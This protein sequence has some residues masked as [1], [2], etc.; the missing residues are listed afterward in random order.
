[1][2]INRHKLDFVK[3]FNKNPGTTNVINGV[4]YDD[5]YFVNHYDSNTEAKLI[6]QNNFYIGEVLTSSSTGDGSEKLTI[7]EAIKKSIGPNTTDL[8]ALK[9]AVT[10]GAIAYYQNGVL[11]GTNNE[12]TS[13]NKS[14]DLFTLLKNYVLYIE[15]V[16]SAES[17]TTTEGDGEGVIKPPTQNS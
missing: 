17:G 4:S 9:D 15:K 16:P 2:Y 5:A 8:F 13:G 6:W 10:D 1:M 3:I 11:Y 7:L 12:N 14:I